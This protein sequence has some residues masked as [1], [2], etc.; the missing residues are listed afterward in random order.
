MEKGIMLMII[1]G[2]LLLISAI[3][4]GFKRLKDKS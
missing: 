1:G 2:I 3:A 4:Y